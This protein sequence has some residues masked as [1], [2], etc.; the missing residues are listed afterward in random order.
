MDIFGLGIVKG[1]GE[2]EK[3]RGI[4]YP[5][6]KVRVVKAVRLPNFGFFLK[7]SNQI[8][9]AYFN[10]HSILN[11][12]VPPTEIDLKSDYPNK[13]NILNFVSESYMKEQSPTF[14]YFS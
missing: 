12:S 5:L 14:D 10:D 1:R 11:S 2:I 7:L 13:L 6:R 3:N 9:I 8:V 4:A